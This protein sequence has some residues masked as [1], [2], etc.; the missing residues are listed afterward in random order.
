MFSQLP[1]VRHSVGKAG[2][3]TSALSVRRFAFPH[4]TFQFSVFSLLTDSTTKPLNYLLP[5][6]RH[7]SRVLIPINS[8]F[9][10]RRSTFGVFPPPR[11]SDHS[12]IQLLN[13]STSS[14]P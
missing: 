14:V 12:T 4:S 9:G 10:V 7:R 3:P 8:T 2:T 11:R 13:F 1:S 5:W 6:S